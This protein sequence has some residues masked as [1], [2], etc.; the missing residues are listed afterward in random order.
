LT[1]RGGGGQ[2]EVQTVVKAPEGTKLG[3]LKEGGRTEEQEGPNCS[4]STP[5]VVVKAGGGRARQGG[6]PRRPTNG[7]VGPRAGDVGQET[8]F[9]SG[10]VCGDSDVRSSLSG[11][12]H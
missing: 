4:S 2:S 12:R 6:G 11:F 1:G 9:L 5:K 8:K 3:Q 10:T 7:Y